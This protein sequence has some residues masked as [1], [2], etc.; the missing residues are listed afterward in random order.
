MSV[1]HLHI[2]LTSH[3]YSS[4]LDTRFSSHTRCSHL[5]NIHH[6]SNLIFYVEKR[7]CFQSHVY[8][9]DYLKQYQLGLHFYLA[10]ASLAVD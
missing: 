2:K 8:F 7:F 9:L 5:L 6:I 3:T 4:N 1:Q 10:P